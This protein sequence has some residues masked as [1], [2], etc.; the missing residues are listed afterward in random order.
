MCQSR[1]STKIKLC[2]PNL[3]SG[4]TE[5]W[6]DK[7][8]AP[9]IQMLNDYG[10]RTIGCCCG[11]GKWKGSVFIQNKYTENVFEMYTALHIKRKRKFYAKMKD[12]YFKPCF[13]K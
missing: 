5:V 12:G 1:N 9:L 3:H 13:I 8:I 7:C 4:K 10:V 6:V 2:Q 11:H